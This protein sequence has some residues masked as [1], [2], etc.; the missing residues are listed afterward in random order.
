MG[1]VGAPRVRL[2]VLNYNGGQLVERCVEHLERVDWPADRLEIVVVDNASTD[3]SDL[4]LEAHDRVR[5]IRSERNLGF[6][7][8]NLGLRDRDGVDFV[9]LINN[10]AFVEPDFLTPL[11]ELLESSPTIGA[12]C[13]K[14]LLAHRFTPM[15]LVSG[16]R[17]IGSDTRT[18]GVQVSGVEVEGQER[19]RHAHWAK[20]FYGSEQGPKEV[21][22]F[23]W[24]DGDARLGLPVLGDEVRARVRLS[25][26]TPTDVVLDAGAGEAR[27]TI[28]PVPS[29][30]DIAIGPERI[31]VIN[32]VGS[33]LVRG[34][35]AGDRGFLEQDLGQ[36]DVAQD[37]FAWCGA[38]VLFR[39]EYLDDVGLFDERFFMYYEDTDLAW[40]GR[41]RGWR[42][43]YEPTSLI[44]HVHA[45]TSVEGSPMFNHF[46][47]RNRLAMLTK[48]AP[49]SMV[50]TAVA[51]D[52]KEV[53][54]Y[55]WRDIVRRALRLRR[56]TP[57][58]VLRRLRALGAY[59]AMLPGLLIDRR[60][61]RGG[62]TV[63]D[64]ALVGWAE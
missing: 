33:R 4:P 57:R 24:S 41:L 1:P 62:R 32:N 64:E 12:A 14:I 23:Q 17:R 18:L 3:G 22:P 15:T 35:H 43:R 11:V 47:R 34:G 9:G 55:G 38:G 61:I 13:P 26:P 60:R 31:D 10:D 54:M 21:G 48:S 7:A 63:P 29:W 19:W 46:V 20:G 2:V 52:L 51:Q 37:V 39:G 42:Y 27:A 28:G 49:A 30:V 53:A 56:P 45:A 5:L 36:Y 16:T 6:P 59:L 50:A 8:N 58:F 40:R 44:R 25:A